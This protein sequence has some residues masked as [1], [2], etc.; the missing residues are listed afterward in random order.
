MTAR[1]HL[2]VA[3]FVAVFAW[4]LLTTSRERAWG[5]AQAMWEVAERMVSARALD[6]E[7]RWPEDIPAGRGGKYYGIA[8]IGPSLVHVPGVV[9]EKVVHAIAP[10]F[11]PLVL[12]F[13]VHLAPAALGALACVLLFLFL[14]DLGISRRTASATVAIFA[15]AT[16]AWV[17]ARSPYSEI[18]QL[19]AFLGLVRQVLRTADAPTRGRALALGAWAGVALNAKYVFALAIVGGLVIVAWSLRHRRGE[20]LRALAWTAAAGAPFALLALAYNAAR[21]GSITASGYEPY[22]A[23]YFGG[24]AFDGAWGMLASPNKSALLYSPPLVLALLGAPAAFRAKPRLAFAIVALCVPTFLVYCTYRS[25]SGDYAWGPRFFVWMVPPLLV[26]IAW[27]IDNLSRAKR[28]VAAAVITAGICIQLLGISLYWDHFIRLAIDTKNQWLG[29]PNRAGSYIPARGRGHC[30]SCFEDTY[31]IMWTPA[32]QPIRGNWWL[33]KSLA[34]GDTA[35]EAQQTAPWRTYTSL[36]VHLDENYA[37]LRLD[38]WVMLW[39][40]DAPATEG[41]GIALLIVMLGG[42]GFGA[43]RWLRYH[44]SR[45]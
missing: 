13:A 28:A 2:C 14:D 5:D 16:T 7:M 15:G 41:L 18:L 42:T 30:D 44:R 21:W 43:A 9:I 26:P 45:T 35:A 8:P 34:R 33:L 11:D 39:W 10:R 27:F 31:E 4:N 38:W 32:F 40:R 6:I 12:P 36:D 23:A 29:Q 20:L 3:M 17:Y 24:S 37:R 19:A 25:W 1:R 22:F